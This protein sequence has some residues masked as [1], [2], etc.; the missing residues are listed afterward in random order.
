MTPKSKTPEPCGRPAL[1]RWGIRWTSRPKRE[2]GRCVSGG[3]PDAAMVTS[4]AKQGSYP[5]SLP[6]SEFS[7]RLSEGVAQKERLRAGD[8]VSR[9]RVE[10]SAILVRRQDCAYGEARERQATHGLGDGMLVAPAPGFDVAGD[11]NGSTF[12]ESERH[13]CVEKL[14]QRG[15]KLLV[16]GAT[17]PCGGSL[18]RRANLGHRVA[19][20][21]HG[22]GVAS[23]DFRHE[24]CVP[25]TERARTQI[26]RLRFRR[27]AHL[28][29]VCG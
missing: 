15:A 20:R 2:D 29:S 23:T 17:V 21:A 28:T 10:S 27:V 25:A 26:D 6:A 12:C 16:R 14:G 5:A 4:S 1:P 8:S 22:V 19:H 3:A 24:A 9:R 11:T 18:D 7:A 13:C